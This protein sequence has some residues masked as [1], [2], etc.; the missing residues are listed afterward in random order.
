MDVMS[1]A[2]TSVDGTESRQSHGKAAQGSRSRGSVLDGVEQ[3]CVG[4][5]RDGWVGTDVDGEGLGWVRLSW[6]SE[7]LR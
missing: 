4:R 5:N 2:W 1:I 3:R 7:M 6:S